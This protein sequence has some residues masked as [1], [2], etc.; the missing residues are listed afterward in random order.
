MHSEK[1]GGNKTDVARQ[2]ICIYF[3][4]QAFY[5]DLNSM[6]YQTRN[7]YSQQQK[8]SLCLSALVLCH[9]FCFNLLDFTASK[10]KWKCQVLPHLVWDVKGVMTSMDMPPLAVLNPDDTN[11]CCLYI[12]QCCCRRSSQYLYWE[13]YL[14]KLRV[15]VKFRRKKKILQRLLDSE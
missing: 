15:I 8:E 2:A 11:T 9:D 4:V 7:Y 12:Q 3:P 1:R 14:L 5:N 6:G 10:P 13:L